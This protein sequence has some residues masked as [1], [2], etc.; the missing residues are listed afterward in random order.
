MSRQQIDSMMIELA[1]SYGG[2]ADDEPDSEVMSRLAPGL[3]GLI[4]SDLTDPPPRINS[5]RA[6]TSGSSLLIRAL[7][8]L[9]VEPNDATV[10]VAMGGRGPRTLT[11]MLY[12]IPDIKA[13]RL[14]AEVESAI[15]LPPQGRWR[16]RQVDGRAVR[17]S[18]GTEFTVAFWARDGLVVHVAGSSEDV[19]RTAPLL[20]R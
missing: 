18:S 16:D 1:V 12:E 19:E 17:W 20:P 9:E 2:L 6:S 10:V 4:P 3:E 5:V 14:L 7:R 15:T 11:V 8:R 13:D